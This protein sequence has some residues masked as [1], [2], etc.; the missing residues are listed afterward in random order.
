M[1]KNGMKCKDCGYNCHKKCAK[2]VGKNCPGEVPSLSKIDTGEY[3]E[4]V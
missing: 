2:D 1:Y 3:S 4:L